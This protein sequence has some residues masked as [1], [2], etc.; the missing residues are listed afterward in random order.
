MICFASAV[1]LIVTGY[2]VV[3]GQQQLSTIQTKE[4]VYIAIGRSW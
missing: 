3:T 4:Y 1:A 2:T